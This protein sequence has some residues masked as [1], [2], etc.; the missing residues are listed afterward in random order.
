MIG[1]KS[2]FMSFR[3]K[4][5]ETGKVEVIMVQADKCR[6]ICDIVIPILVHR[7]YFPAPDAS[8]EEKREYREKLA[9]YKQH[10]AEKQRKRQ[11]LMNV[12][13][14]RQINEPYMREILKNALINAVND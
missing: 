11:K 1:R 12:F 8:K 2:T 7:P 10:L 14:G 9:I 3:V 6:R 13:K 5:N 4:S